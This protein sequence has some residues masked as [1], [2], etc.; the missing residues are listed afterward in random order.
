[1]N[2]RKGGTPPPPSGTMCKAQQAKLRDDRQKATNIKNESGGFHLVEVNSPI[3]MPSSTIWIIAAIICLLI[4]A[5]IYRRRAKKHAHKKAFTRNGGDLD[6]FHEYLQWV[7]SPRT[8]PSTTI[9]EMLPVIQALQTIQPQ[10]L[11]LEKPNPSTQ[12]GPARLPTTYTTAEIHQEQQKIQDA[13]SRR[14]EWDNM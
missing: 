6:D 13:V 2:R 1:M 4:A 12:S 9:T 14:K 5:F 3:N 7:K 8:K 11:T 10:T